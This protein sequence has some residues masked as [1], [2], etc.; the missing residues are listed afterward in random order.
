VSTVRI[1]VTE[2]FEPLQ[3]L[4]SSILE[5]RPN[6]QVVGI[7]SDALKAL[8]LARQLQ[9]DV[10]LLDIDLGGANGVDTARQFRVI[11]AKSRIVVIGLESSVAIVRALF[12]LGVSGYVAKNCLTRELPDAVEAAT[13]G[14]QFVSNG[15]TDDFANATEP[16]NPDRLFSKVPIRSLP[17][18]QQRIHIVRDHDLK[19]RPFCQKRT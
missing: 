6:W 2:D 15:L 13:Q 10:I 17:P 11:A 9:P 4:I 3:R 14:R 12:N 7:V 5:Q 18:V 16:Q 8:R 1:L 19:L